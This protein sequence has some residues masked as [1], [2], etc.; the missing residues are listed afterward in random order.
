MGSTSPPS[1]ENVQKKG[2]KKLPQN[3]WIR[4]GPPP[5]L[6]DNVRKEAAFFS[7]L[8]PLAVLVLNNMAMF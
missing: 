4:V 6:L 1:I 2:Q 8:L 7:G 3:F 5:S